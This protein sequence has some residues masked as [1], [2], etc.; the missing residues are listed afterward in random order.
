MQ[1]ELKP[2]RSTLSKAYY[3]RGVPEFVTHD[4]V[5]ERIDAGWQEVGDPR[6]VSQHDVHAHEEVVTPKGFF[7]NLA[8]HRHDSLRVE[9]RPAQ[10]E[11]HDH[12]D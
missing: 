10:E 12:R 4:V 6:N 7:H 1:C 3:L 8:V 11:R 9:R 5:E 2:L